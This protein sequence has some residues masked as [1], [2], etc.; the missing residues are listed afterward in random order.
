[1][2]REH[3]PD[4]EYPFSTGG[5]A[6]TLID[7]LYYLGALAVLSMAL[8]VIASSFVTDPTQADLVLGLGIVAG[9][10]GLLC[11]GVDAVLLYHHP[12][13]PWPW[14]VVADTAIPRREQ[15]CVVAA[16]CFLGAVGLALFAPFAFT[17]PFVPPAEPV[18]R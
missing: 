12:E 16:L 3:T 10:V 11:W 4:T 8:G 2:S 15:A 18:G 1:M 9:S 6:P 17:L 13:W 7:L 14:P 5:P